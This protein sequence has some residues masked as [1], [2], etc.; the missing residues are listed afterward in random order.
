MDVGNSR[1]EMVLM[2]QRSQSDHSENIAMHTVGDAPLNI[3]E[4]EMK[5]Q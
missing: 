3:N 1:S 2:I 4:I 5:A